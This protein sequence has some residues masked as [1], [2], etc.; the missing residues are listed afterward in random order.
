MPSLTTTT[1]NKNRE[2]EA[3]SIKLDVINNLESV[4]PPADHELDEDELVHEPENTEADGTGEED[5][6]EAVH[7]SGNP[8]QINP[9]EEQDID[10]L[11]HQKNEGLPDQE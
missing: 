1:K 4:D 8:I 10:D 3:N 6:D 5:P 2:P 11:L 7:R 9:E